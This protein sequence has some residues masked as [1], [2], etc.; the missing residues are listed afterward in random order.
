M[1]GPT[2]CINGSGPK[3][4]HLLNTASL[5]K[6]Y[7]NFL[8][9]YFVFY[10]IIFYRNIIIQQNSEK[11]CWY[12]YTRKFGMGWLQ[13]ILSLNQSEQ[14]KLHIPQSAQQKE[15]EQRI[16][17]QINPAYFASSP[18]Q[19]DQYW[20]RYVNG[21]E[22]DYLWRRLSDNFYQKDVVP[23][24]YLE[25][26]NACYEAYNANPLAFAIIELPPQSSSLCLDSF[27]K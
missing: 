3:N 12:W 26:H 7:S 22:E 20:S 19:E 2:F 24:T 4:S 14:A 10:V 21:T 5:L 9:Q 23:S 27:S 11:L 18:T 25:I 6:I 15:L 16:A 8:L 17:E 13:R 1:N